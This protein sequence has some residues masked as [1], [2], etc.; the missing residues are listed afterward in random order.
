MDMS[1]TYLAFDR[2]IDNSIKSEARL[3]RIGL[4]KRIYE[5]SINKPLPPKKVCMFLTKTK[6]NVV[7][8]L[9]T[10]RGIKGKILSQKFLVIPKENYQM[11]MNQGVCRK[12]F[13]SETK[14]DESDYIVSQQIH[15]PFKNG[16]KKSLK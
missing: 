9:A 10:D 2:Y 6:E 11:E 14:F 3:K 5:L 1:D 16:N 13:N 12:H 8:I 7:D 15:E 4:F